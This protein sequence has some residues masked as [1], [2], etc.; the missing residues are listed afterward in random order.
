MQTRLPDDLLST[1]DGQRAE[2]ILR[3]CVHCGFCNAT[4]PTY[5]LRGD[6]LDGPR[7]R[8]YLIKTFLESGEQS[9]RVRQHLD[10][11]LTCR[12]CETTCPSGVRYGELLEIARDKLAEDRGPWRRLVVSLLLRFVP[13]PRLFRAL[14]NLGNAVRRAL[15]AVLRDVVPRPTRASGYVPSARPRK[16]I[17]LDGCVQRAVT[18][19]VNEHLKRLL[20]ARGIQC[21]TV[22]DEGCCGSLAL[23]LGDTQ[24]ALAAMQNNVEALAEVLPDAEAVISTASGCGVTVKDY[25]RHLAGTY[26]AREAERIADRTRDVAEYLASLGVAFAPALPQRRIAWHAPCTLQHGQRVRGIVEQLLRS[27]GYE[28]TAVADP[29]LCCGSAGT[30]SILEPELSTQLRDNKLAA[31]SMDAPELIA[32]ANIGCQTHLASAAGV[33]VVHWLTLL[34]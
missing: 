13:K 34:R 11:C 33:P 21:L 2:A 15:P 31:L 5:Q 25:G 9:P 17:L 27:A 1:A 23:H 8:I 7:G 6:E 18:P 22:A 29:H 32:T 24:R 28:L 30:Y 16:V 12:S 3:A 26:C 10:R 14:V 20:D 19:D 4:C